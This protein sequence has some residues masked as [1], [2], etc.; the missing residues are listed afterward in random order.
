VC[1]T[2]AWLHRAVEQGRR[3]LFEGAQGSLLDI[4]HGSYPYVT[5]SN[6]SAAGIAAGSG[7]PTR[8]IDRW[9]GVVKAY[10]TR[11]GGGPFPTEQDN[12]VGERIRRAGKE[13][14]TV[15]GRPRRCGWFDVV[16]ARH[17]ARVSGSTELAV[18][19][20]DVL[21]GIEELKVAVAYERDG[22]RVDDLPAALADFERCR[23]VYETFPGWSEPI[24]EV[25]RWADLPGQARAYVDFVGQQVGVPVR[26]VSVG[27]DRRQ[28]ILLP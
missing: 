8:K 20:L 17:G 7:M 15:T 28:T 27:P 2:T 16:A 26:I 22:R 5:S 23:P 13:F 3:L 21:S 1:D 6:S 25:T 4:D 24:T 14:G 11:V 12:A 19:L 9:I 10:S 18:M